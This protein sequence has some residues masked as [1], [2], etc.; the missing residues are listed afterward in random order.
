MPATTT[1]RRKPPTK[2]IKITPTKPTTQ[3]NYNPDKTLSTTGHKTLPQPTT[4]PMTTTK[5]RAK[6]EEKN[7]SLRRR[8]EEKKREKK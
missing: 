7:F 5:E 1:I 2:A 4:K 8:S 3:K 6:R